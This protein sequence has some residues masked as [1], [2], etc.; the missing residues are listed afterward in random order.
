M[1]KVQSHENATGAEPVVFDNVSK[2]YPDGSIG[3]QDINLTCEAGQITVFVGPSGCGKTTTLRMINRMIEPSDGQVFIGDTDTSTL[4]QTTLRRGIGYVIQSAGLFPHRTIIDNIATVPLLL[5]ANRRQARADA[6]ELMTKVGLDQ[7]MAKKYP[8][9]LSGGQQQRVGVARPLASNPPV[10]LMD[11]PFSAVDPIV[12][13]DLQAELLRLQSELAKTVVL[14]THDLDE[15][16]MLADKLVL[17]EQGGRIAHEG[18]PED[19]LLR[20][21]SAFVRDFTGDSGIRWL[22]TLSTSE[23]EPGKARPVEP[24]LVQVEDTDWFL[25]LDEHEAPLLWQQREGA[26]VTVQVPCRS[27]YTHGQDPV[28]V[29]FDSAVLSPVS[30]AVATDASNRFLGFSGMDDFSAVIA[31]ERRKPR[32]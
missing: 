11:E 24:D 10:L 4:D 12:R 5:G 13:S 15:A 23:L 21:A 22:S 29:A 16:I 31:A 32:V 7:D 8:H 17:F 18:T 14:V 1:P 3:V 20:P 2:T 26:T 6:L 27:T 25:T 19:L 30:L 28:R 9:Q